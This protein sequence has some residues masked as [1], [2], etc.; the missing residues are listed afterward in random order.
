MCPVLNQQEHFFYVTRLVLRV[1][2]RVGCVR[3]VFCG[4]PNRNKVLREEHCF[5]C[6]VVG[7]DSQSNLY[8]LS[9]LATRTAALRVSAASTCRPSETAG[10]VDTAM[11]QLHALS[12]A[13]G[14]FSAVEES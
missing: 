13:H 7:S 9:Y 14:L 11:R 2:A 12:F 3:A 8:V 1:V 5:V 6:L 4:L 10:G